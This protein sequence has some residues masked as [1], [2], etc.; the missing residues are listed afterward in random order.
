MLGKIEG[1]RRRGRQR[2]RWLDGI[3]DSMDMSLSKL[4][5]MVMDREAW[6]AAFHGVAK[7]QTWLSN[8]STTKDVG[9]PPGKKHWW[10]KPQER[11][12]WGPRTISSLSLHTSRPQAV[13]N[14]LSPASAP[15]INPGCT[16]PT[17]VIWI[18]WWNHDFP[19]EASK[20]PSM[21]S[22]YQLSWGEGG[23]CSFPRQGWV[24]GLVTAF[25]LPLMGLIGEGKGKPLQL[26]CLE[27]SVDRGAW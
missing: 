17:K 18:F 6:H 9:P 23:G 15:Q 7:S 12:R 11:G 13:N 10:R 16:P 27:N 2:M 8:W 4:Q 21:H 14:N 25:P 1:G 26:S 3:T 5:E 20:L 19:W 22:P 24:A